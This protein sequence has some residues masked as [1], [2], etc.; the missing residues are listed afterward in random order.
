MIREIEPKDFKTVANYEKE[1]CIISFGD[2]AITDIG[3][4]IKKLEDCYRKEKEG[5]LVYEQDSTVVGWLWMAI[6]TNYLT[7]DSYSVF[8]SFYIDEK[9][10]STSV[11]DELF[12]AG[13][14]FCRKHKS[15]SITGKVNYNNMPMRILYK[16]YGFMPTTIT[17]EYNYK[18]DMTTNDKVNDKEQD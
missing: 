16:K 15:K 2:E 11:V 12:E 6:K 14:D 4:H 13:M 18:D 1:I 3:F 9:Y 10:R 17:M 7:K 5:M 8:K